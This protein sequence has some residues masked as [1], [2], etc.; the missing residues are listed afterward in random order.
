MRKSADEESSAGDSMRG[1]SSI[2]VSGVFVFLANVSFAQSTEKS[3]TANKSSDDIYRRIVNAFIG[4]HAETSFNVQSDLW[5]SSSDL[6]TLNAIF[7]THL[8][9][10]PSLTIR[11]WSKVIS[12][13]LQ[14]SDHQCEKTCD[15]FEKN[16]PKMVTRNLDKHPKTPGDD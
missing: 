5:G 4:L 15:E 13:E 11:D 6:S 3:L 1:L 16:V 12:E 8:C 14:C 2:I 7:D 10:G 9:S